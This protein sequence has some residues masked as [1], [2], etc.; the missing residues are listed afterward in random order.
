MEAYCVDIEEFIHVD[1]ILDAQVVVAFLDGQFGEDGVWIFVVF[2]KISESAV[3]WVDEI[4]RSNNDPF[5]FLGGT[6][7]GDFDK[8]ILIEP[9]LHY[10]VH[11]VYAL[12][13][14]SQSVVLEEMF[15]LRVV[16]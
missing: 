4:G 3:F 2:L 10:F 12:V 14:L 16:E 15:H 6:A 7:R 5:I 9:L 13:I 1:G 8:Y 11:V